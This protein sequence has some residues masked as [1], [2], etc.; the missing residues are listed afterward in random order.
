MAKHDQPQDRLNHPGKKLDGSSAGLH[1]IDRGKE[2]A[3]EALSGGMI[4]RLEIAQAMLHRPR[5][6]VLDEPTV[7]L[8]PTAKHAVWQ[9]IG[10]VRQ[11]FG[12]SVLMTTHDMEEADHLCDTVAF[13]HQGRLL[14]SG[15]PAELEGALGA[16]ASLD[17]VF[18][19]YAG[20]S[21]TEGGNLRDV[22]Q[23]RQTA[24]RLE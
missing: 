9:R 4:R 3:G 15:S 24:R 10:D 5:V 13:M 6:L 7:G 17:D 19:Y 22:A 16:G 8:D 2:S 14:A 18:A 21:I 23:T 20:A 1:A 11:Q 12:T